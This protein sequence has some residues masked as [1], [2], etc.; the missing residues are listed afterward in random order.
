MTSKFGV[1]NAPFHVGGKSG[2]VDT[3]YLGTFRKSA[4]ERVG[5]FD[6][7]FIRA[8]DWEMN[9]RIRETGGRV[10]FNPAMKVTYRPR[11][12]I[13]TLRTQ[14]LQY[15]QWRRKVMQMHPETSRRLSALRYFAPPLA[16]VSLIA[17]TV[18]GIAGLLFANWMVIGFVAPVS[19]LAVI[20]LVAIS[21]LR[22]E[23]LKVCVRI[24]IVLITMHMSW[25]WGFLTSPVI[26]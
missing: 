11:R 25:G 7:S 16:V 18:L 6:E 2:E 14:Y 26:K 10:W 5:Y 20:K 9:H 17:G 15:G 4:L 19:Y 1:G 3:V 22:N 13:K 24:P 21:A 12:T 23:P 8:Q